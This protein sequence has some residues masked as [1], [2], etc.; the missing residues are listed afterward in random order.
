[1]YSYLVKKLPNDQME[2]FDRNLS[3]KIYNECPDD[4]HHS[5]KTETKR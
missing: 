4:S 1:M 5:I 3:L 2:I